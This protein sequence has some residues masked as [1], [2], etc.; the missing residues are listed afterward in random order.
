MK[1]LLLPLV[2][3]FQFAHATSNYPQA[4]KIPQI[5]TRFGTLIEDPYKW[6]ENHSD[7]DLWDWIQ[8]QKDFTNSYLDAVQME[9]FASGT[10]KFR[11]I[12]DEQNKVTES[13]SQVI[14]RSMPSIQD[15][16]DSMGKDENRFIR[17]HSSYELKSV[18]NQFESSTYQIQSNTVANGDLKRVLI[19]RKSDNRV[20]DILMVKFYTFVTWA[21][22]NSFYYITD[23]DQH[24]G[25]G[26]PGLFKHT[27]GEMQSEDRLILKGKSASSTLTIHQIGQSFFVE[28]DETIGAIQLSSGKVTNRLPLN[29][30]IVDVN[31]APEI[32]VKIKSFEKANNGEFYKLRL[33]DGAR[34]LFVAEQNFVLDKSIELSQ[35]KSL[36]IG[37]KDGSNV[38]A[39][40]DIQ[41][42]IDLIDLNDGTIEYLGFQEGILKLSLDTYSSPKR[43]FSFD[44]TTKELKLLA[45]QTYPIEV[46]AEKIN[47]TASNGQPAS[48]WVMRKKG[49]ELNP[50]TP[51]I[52]Y[53]YG[54]FRVAVTP[55]FGMYESL[56][57][58]ERGGAFVVVTLPGS[59][60]YGE[61]WYQLA[62]VGGRTN[63][64]DSFALAA[65]ELFKRGWTS[66]DHIGMMGASNGGTLTAGTLQRHSDIFKAAV[67]IVG[68]MDLINFTLF[69]AGKYWTNDY[70]NPFIEE[71]F[72]AIFPLS[73]YHNLEKRDY[74]ATMVMTAAF[75]DRVVPMHSYKYLARLQ[76]YNTSQAPILL[77]HKEWG[78]HARASG[79][80]RESSRFVAAF[81]TFFAQQ[82]G[83]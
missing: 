51:T 60:D 36:I 70:G 14:I 43:I 49:V 48:M 55:A 34:R 57:W 54:G 47:Y 53:G 46:E 76:E 16:I 78:G 24:I 64:W 29:G 81:Y 72:K 79:S 4:K 12:R 26:K 10:L 6:M 83:L 66:P 22:D 35:D 39:I 61:S 71:D 44:L 59:L 80:A 3:L 11:K 63:S 82:L 74:P 62:R 52:L 32:E 18:L 9:N 37:L 27:V 77:Y 40:Y 75:D 69:T 8:E 56:S 17:W 30:E 15:D 19:T 1:S 50:K 28:V 2:L 7:P 23:M 45:S 41:N 31:D 20:V 25:G 5:E 21:D 42:G 13:A 68:V 65:Q 33:R 73:P 67:P 38:A 58:M